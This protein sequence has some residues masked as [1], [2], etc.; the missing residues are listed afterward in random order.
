[1][2]HILRWHMVYRFVDS[3]RTTKSVWRTRCL[4]AT[5]ATTSTS[6]TASTSSTR[7]SWKT[8][9]SATTVFSRYCRIIRMSAGSTSTARYVEQCRS[10]GI[11]R[12]TVRQV[13]L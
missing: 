7:V 12:T 4:S 10:A 8:R 6:S 5:T 9:M 1:M 13:V 11:Y 2:R 3:Y